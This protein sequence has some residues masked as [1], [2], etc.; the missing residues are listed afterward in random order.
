MGQGDARWDPTWGRGRSGQGRP[1]FGATVITAWHVERP[2]TAAALEAIEWDVVRARRSGALVAPA[3]FGRTHL[4]RVVAERINPVQW[5]SV[6]LPN[7]VFDV[8]G[9]CRCVIGLHAGSAEPVGDPVAALARVL[10]GLWSEGRSLLLLVDDAEHMPERTLHG[11]LE[12]AELHAPTLVLLFAARAEA[13]AGH[14]VFG[15]DRERFPVVRLEKPL[16]ASEARAYV[17]HR[18]ARSGASADLAAR[19]GDQAIARLHALSG[20]EVARLHA[21]AQLLVE[22]PADG[23]DEAWARFARDERGLLELL[24]VPAD[25]GAPPRPE[26]DAT[27]AG[28]SD[29]PQDRSA[30]WDEPAPAAPP[31]RPDPLR[32]DAAPPPTEPAGGAV[33]SEP[34]SRPPPAS[35]RRRRRRRRL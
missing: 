11:V 10:E 24:A 4:L 3:G 2:E 16:D 8:A 6:Y 15:S 29:P 5:E 31:E 23:P 20:G 9:L 26:H 22:T 34:G 21:L 12:L 33:P 14:P 30:G 32:G 25:T 35:S 13:V 28:P 27:R 18:L 1:P 17:E 19:F 7:P